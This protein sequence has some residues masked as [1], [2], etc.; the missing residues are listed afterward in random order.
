MLKSLIQRH[1]KFTGSDVARTILLAWD[2]HR[3]MFKKVYPAEYRRALTEA[4]AL[5]KA[6]DAEAQLM[7]AYKASAP[8]K[9]RDAFEELK[10][11]AH[12][13]SVKNPPKAPVTK[14]APQDPKTDLKVG[15]GEVADT[16]SLAVLPVFSTSSTACASA[17]LD[18]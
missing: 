8:G 1:L 4:A 7:E 9:P 10:Q 5:A 17:Q 14:H 3:P 15:W 11:I 13:F 16:C 6:E 2:R 18:P 12:K